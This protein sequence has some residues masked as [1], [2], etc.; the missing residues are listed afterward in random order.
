MSRVEEKRRVL[1][2]QQV[3]G[4]RKRLG[5]EEWQGLK[6][7]LGT[8]MSDGEAIQHGNEVEVIWINPDSYD[9]KGTSDNSGLERTGHGCS[10]VFGLE[11][12]SGA[13]HGR[14]D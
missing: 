5:Y 10:G 9:L 3:R 6:Q 13:W 7:W 8:G 4:G 11:P 2:R 1:V 14:I 12:S